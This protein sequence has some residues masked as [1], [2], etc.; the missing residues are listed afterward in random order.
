[1]A[2]VDDVAAQIAA[3]VTRIGVST[4]A[5][6][7]GQVGDPV[8]PTYGTPSGG[9]VDLAAPLQISGPANAGP[10]THLVFHGAD[11]VIAVRPV[12]TPASFN[13]DGLIEV[14]SAAIT[15]SIGA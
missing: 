5:D 12:G 4:T 15:V 1:M 14:T 3:D 8:Q 13:S 10:V 6:E 2:F 9:A 11:G 7:T